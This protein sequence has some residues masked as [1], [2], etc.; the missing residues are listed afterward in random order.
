MRR[1]P[2]RRS[3]STLAIRFEFAVLYATSAY[4]T[5]DAIASGIG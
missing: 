5:L 3:L 2:K 4:I 1:P